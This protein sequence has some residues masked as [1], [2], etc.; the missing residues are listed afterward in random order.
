[1]LL[2][3]IESIKLDWNKQGSRAFPGKPPLAYLQDRHQVSRYNPRP[4]IWIDHEYR[5]LLADGSPFWAAEP[6]GLDC[7][8]EEDFAYLREN[9]FVVDVNLK[10]FPRRWNERVTVVLIRRDRG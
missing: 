4:T 7:D 3:S 9:G 10:D 1:V 2:V 6:Y 8:A 5:G